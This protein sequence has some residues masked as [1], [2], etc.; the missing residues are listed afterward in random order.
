MCRSSYPLIGFLTDEIEILVLSSNYIA[1][2]SSWLG[3]W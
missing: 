2:Q 3:I 1:D